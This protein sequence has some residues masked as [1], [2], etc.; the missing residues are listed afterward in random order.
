MRQ[1]CQ[2]KG[3]HAVQD[4]PSISASRS[5][6]GKV[7]E[8]L[9][10]CSCVSRACVRIVAIFSSRR[11]CVN[12]VYEDDCWLARFGSSK[13]TLHSTFVAAAHADFTEENLSVT[14]SGAM[15]NL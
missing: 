13:D 3:K 1:V 11:K 5:G 6:L 12:L 8:R 14:G 7:N 4:G 15:S 2:G 10:G 9:T